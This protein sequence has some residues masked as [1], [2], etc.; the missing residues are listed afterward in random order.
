MNVLIITP[1]RPE[2]RQMRKLFVGHPATSRIRF[3]YA[4]KWAEAREKIARLP[5]ASRQLR[6]IMTAPYLPNEHADL[7][8]ESAWM[9]ALTNITTV[10][11][12]FTDCEEKIRGCRI[13]GELNDQSST[14]KAR[15]F[16][17]SMSWD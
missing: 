10:M 6:L 14:Q 16:L 12:A 8:R 7:V 3:V 9:D 17:R 2:Q 4:S 11:I 1:S 15:S 13:F 5:Q